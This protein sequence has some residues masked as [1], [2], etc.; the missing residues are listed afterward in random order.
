MTFEEA[1]ALEMVTR[2]CRAN[3]E[4]IKSATD[5]MKGAAEVGVQGGSRENQAFA[6]VRAG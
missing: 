2:G 4:M 3:C 5:G 1:L 6:I